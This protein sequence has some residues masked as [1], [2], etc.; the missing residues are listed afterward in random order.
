MTSGRAHF[1]GV[2]L[3]VVCN[4]TSTTVS[5]IMDTLSLP[6]Q[7]LLVYSLHESLTKS[8]FHLFKKSQGC[9]KIIDKNELHWSD[10]RFS[11]EIAAIMSGVGLFIVL[12]DCTDNRLRSLHTGSYNFKMIMKHSANCPISC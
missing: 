9:Q 1:F 5:C 11:I 6:C 2:H 8:H 12:D 3:C 7:G 4:I 10:K